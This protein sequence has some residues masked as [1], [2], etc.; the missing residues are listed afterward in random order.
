MHT[1]DKDIPSAPSKIM[2]KVW[3]GTD[4][5]GRLKAYDGTT[6]LIAE[7]KSADYREGE[8]K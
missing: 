1:A 2:M 4:V 7:Y 3:L 5:D 8:A 6:P